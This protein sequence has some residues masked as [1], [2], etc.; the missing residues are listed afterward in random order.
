MRKYSVVIF[1]IL[2]LISSLSLNAN[3][4]S[5]NGALSSLDWQK[6]NLENLIRGKIDKTLSPI[7]KYSDYIVDVEILTTPARKPKFTP[8][9]DSSTTEAVK[10]ESSGIDGVRINDVLPEKLPEDYVV[11]SKLGLEAPLIEDFN[12]FKKDEPKKDNNAQKAELPTFEQ[13]WKFNKSLDIF[14][15]LEQVRIQIRLSKDLQETTRQTVSE[16]LNGINFNFNDIKPEIKVSYI[17]LS[18]KLEVA[19][20]IN[21]EI[22]ELMQKFEVVLAILIGSLILGVF[23]W[24]LFN[25]WA[26]MSESKQESEMAAEMN[27]GV[28]HGQTEKEDSKTA[29]DMVDNLGDEKLFVNGVER[30]ETFL[31]NQKNEAILM[32]KKWINSGTNEENLALRGIVQLLNNDD[33]IVIFN[34]LHQEE[35]DKW[36][37]LLGST[38]QDAELS[39]ANKFISSE[40]I[41]DILVPSEIDDIEAADLLLKLSPEA[42][43]NFVKDDPELGK[44]ILNSMSDGFV[45]NIFQNLNESEIEMAVTS[46]MTYQKDQVSD[47]M[48]DFKGKLAQYQETEKMLPFVNKLINL[49]KVTK[50]HNENPLFKSLASNVKSVKTITDV[51]L[52]SFPG[53]LI[54]RIPADILKT[55]LIQYPMQRKVELVLSL[56]PEKKEFFVDLF[57]PVGSK[58]SDVLDLE[59]EKAQGDIRVMREITDSPEK[60]WDDFVYF[61]RNY[62]KNDNT[63][64]SV[65]EN[66]VA[67]WAQALVDGSSPEDAAGY[68][69]GEATQINNEIKRAA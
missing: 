17:D 42:A 53:S 12:N 54:D 35:R 37:A 23:A 39:I 61:V 49:I 64:Q 51:A 45:A 2:S 41:K 26:K 9:E 13:L 3:D 58:A 59:I 15:N 4:G 30:F 34:S 24:I 55:I 11:F 25:R 16:V 56:S 33:L 57:A 43:A 48:L 10:K 7:I 22:L 1:I 8:T 69:N 32:I 60:A 40:I 44:I 67:T 52:S 28:P 68:A 63:N 50:P 47:Y 19:G 38:L 31:K 6:V 21:Q 27:G 29:L 62:I 20:V 65:F 46:S 14:N 18:E 36:K 5:S 66:L